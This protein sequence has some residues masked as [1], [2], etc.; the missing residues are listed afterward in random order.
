MA[1]I[2][3][4]GLRGLRWYQVLTE[5]WQLWAHVSGHIILVVHAGGNDVGYTRSVDLISAI[6]SD[7]AQCF[8]I[9]TSMTFVWS[10]IVPRS[11][12]ARDVPGPCLENFR[13]KVN[14]Q[15]SKFVRRIGGVVVHHRDL[16]G[17][18]TDLLR[19]DGVH[20]NEIGLDIFNLGLQRGV[21]Q[22]LAVVGRPSVAY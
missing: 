12:L 15:V 21:E 3:W 18:N 7:I 11:L 20:L 10:E 2:R 13:R 17:D 5:C 16:E 6:K 14:A 9:F 22:A 1:R 19:R 4:L 8:A